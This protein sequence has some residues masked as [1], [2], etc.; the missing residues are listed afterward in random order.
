M[1]DG[2][3][4]VAKFRTNFFLLCHCSVRSLWWIKSVCK[5]EIITFR[6]D[7][8]VWTFSFFVITFQKKKLLFFLQH[9]DTI[10]FC[11]KVWTSW[12]SI[13]TFGNFFW[14]FVCTK[15]CA[16]FYPHMACVQISHAH[17][18]YRTPSARFLPRFVMVKVKVIAQR[19]KTPKTAKT[20][21]LEKISLESLTTWWEY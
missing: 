7:H 16:C 12:F 1:T 2:V 9:I 6:S 5:H 4:L 10:S 11:G 8:N 20:S 19:R 17:N 15:I 13:I 14:V 18:F 3:P 21:D